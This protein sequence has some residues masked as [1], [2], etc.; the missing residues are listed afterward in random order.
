[1]SIKN[2]GTVE[3]L[4]TVGTVETLKEGHRDAS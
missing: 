1:M 2:L 4:G 3:Y